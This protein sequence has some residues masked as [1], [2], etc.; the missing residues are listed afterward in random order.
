[1]DRKPEIDAE[2]DQLLDKLLKE[3]PDYFL[4]DDF[5]DHL[6]KK[7]RIRQS[8]K[9]N[10]MEFLTI[11][12]AVAGILI[13]FGATYYF[14][15]KEIFITIKSFVF[16]GYTPVAVVIILFVYFMDKVLLKLLNQL[17]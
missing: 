10:T 15:N 4:P 8:V 13:S 1:M 9:Q 12:G 17:K 11:L 2:N 3:E 5:A 16:N 6:V 7:I 14:L